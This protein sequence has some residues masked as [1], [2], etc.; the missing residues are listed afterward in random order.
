LLAYGPLRPVWINQ[1]GGM[2]FEGRL[3][4]RSVFAKWAPA[5]VGLDLAAERDRLEWAGRY[6]AVPEVLD[7]RAYDSGEYLLT[8]A[9]PGRSA[10]DVRWR[11]E[12]ARA[13]RV[14]GESLREFH[15]ALPVAECPFDWSPDARV[16]K[17]RRETGID[18]Q[19]LEELGVAPAI[20][21]L[22]VNHGDASV[23]NTVLSDD[24]EFAGHVDLSELGAADRWADLAIGMWSVDLNYGPGWAKHYL[25]AY[26]V[27]PDRERL[28]YYEALRAAT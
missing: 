25:D 13:V 1:L 9:L 26:G 18:V 11:R 2:T 14:L 6:V 17:A 24:G 23:P 12:P 27:E 28:D 3:E 16:A 22:V 19:A 20:D 8:L 15:D 4:D 7:Y 5:G 10:V 21:R